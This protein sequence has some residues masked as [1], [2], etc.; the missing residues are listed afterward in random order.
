VKD[1]TTTSD[2]I[3]RPNAIRALCRIIDGTT[4][5]AIERLIK[6]AIVDKSPPISSAALV[7]SYH[8]FPL[9]KEVVRRWASEAQDSIVSAR[10]WTTS[11]AAT[12]FPVNAV[13]SSS[14]FM[15][16]YH[17]L[18]LLYLM[19]QQDR[20]AVA[21]IVQQFSGVFGQDVGRGGS[22]TTLKSPQAVVMLIRFASK[23]IREDAKYQIFPP[24]RLT[25]VV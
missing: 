11:G 6:T 3:Y 22:T 19:R 20:M 25:G 5:Q 15:T 17:G 21:K 4:V 12:P 9:A 23:V 24:R 13:V 18:G 16:Q 7:S 10:A 14:S 8:L 2:I 1:C